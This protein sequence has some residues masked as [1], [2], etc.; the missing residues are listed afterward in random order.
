MLHKK[1]RIRFD[2]TEIEKL[3][4]PKRKLHRERDKLRNVLKNIDTHSLD[5]LDDMDWD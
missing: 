5:D 1:K 2:E 4:Q 3:K